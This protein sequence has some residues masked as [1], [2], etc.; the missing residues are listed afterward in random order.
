MLT[1]TLQIFKNIDGEKKWDWASNKDG[2]NAKVTGGLKKA[3]EG[4]NNV[5]KQDDLIK[6]AM[7][8]GMGEMRKKTP[9][10]QYLLGCQ[11]MLMKLAELVKA[12]TREVR[13]SS[14]KHAAMNL[15]A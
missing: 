7:S 3:L 5:I 14:A 6:N 15:D 9:K 13:R 2:D 10:D 8:T 1:Q 4:L 12:L 11:S